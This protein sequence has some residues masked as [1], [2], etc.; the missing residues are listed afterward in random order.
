M[1][2]PISEEEYLMKEEWTIR[3]AKGASRPKPQRIM[4][5]SAQCPCSCYHIMPPV[6]ISLI[7]SIVT[8]ANSLMVVAVAVHKGLDKN[9]S[10]MYTSNSGSSFKCKPCV[11]N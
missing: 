2:C 3:D 7:Q 8:I 11:Q 6:E 5:Q 10:L 4:I 1:H 9:S